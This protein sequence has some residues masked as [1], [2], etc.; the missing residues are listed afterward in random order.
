MKG[1]VRTLI[2]TSTLASTSR[3]NDVGG[4]M[5]GPAGIIGSVSKN[6]IR[7]TG[8]LRHS[9]ADGLLRSGSLIVGVGKA[10]IKEVG[11]DMASAIELAEDEEAKFKRADNLYQEMDQSVETHTSPP[12][13]LVSMED[14]IAAGK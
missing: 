14:A 1:I 5:F 2:L 13:E 11:Q 7:D 9:S 10:A 12:V 4:T 6:K 3:E 8:V